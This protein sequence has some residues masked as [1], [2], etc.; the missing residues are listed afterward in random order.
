MYEDDDFFDANFPHLPK[1]TEEMRQTS[2]YHDSIFP[3]SSDGVMHAFASCPGCQSLAGYGCLEQ[4]E[5]SEADK[6]QHC[7]FTASSLGSVAQASSSIDNG[8]EYHYG[9]VERSSKA[10]KDA[11]DKAAPLNK[12]V[13]DFASTIFAKLKDLIKGVSSKRIY[14]KPPGAYGCLCITA[15]VN[16]APVDTGFKSSFVDSGESLGLRVAISSATI[17]E[18]KSDASRSMIS[19]LLDGISNQCPVISGPAGIVLSAWSKILNAY[20]EGQES[21]IGGIED[22]L[23]SV[24]LISASGLGT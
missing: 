11:K 18:E 24:H 5:S 3:I 10:Y 20:N 13:K 6:C 1:N 2:M 22:A 17:L 23:N 9:I 14:A 21:F 19:S 7:K 15:N 8:F 4:Y 12:K 16:S